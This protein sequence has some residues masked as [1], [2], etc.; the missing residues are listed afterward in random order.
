MARKRKPNPRRVKAR[1]SYTWKE[2]ADLLGVHER[3]AQ[4][5]K[6]EGLQMLDETTK[7]YLVMGAEV[8]RFLKERSQRHKHALQPGEFYCVACHQ[9]RQSLPHALQVEYTGKRL[10]KHGAQA[11]LRGICQT[12]Q[13]P[14]L[15][16][17]SAAKVQHLRENGLLSPEL[18]I[19]LNG[20]AD[21]SV[22]TDMEIGGHDE[23]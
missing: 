3:T 10:G 21:T 8:K 17:S 20:Y 18:K 7:P 1:R 14:L 22:N 19:V 16:F 9:A 11:L 4:G 12:C 6:A 13:R 15:L 23:S 2:L 5:W